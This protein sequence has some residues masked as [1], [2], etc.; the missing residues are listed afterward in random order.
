MGFFGGGGAAPANMGGATSSVAG[1]AGLVPAPAAGSEY[2]Y[3]RGDATFKNPLIQQSFINTT[4][5]GYNS[6]PL[7]LNTGGSIVPTDNILYLIPH[8]VIP[9]TYTTIAL[10][11]SGGTAGASMKTRMGV[12]ECDFDKLCPTTLILETADTS[13]ANSTSD[14]LVT[15]SQALNKGIYFLACVFTGSSGWLST[16]TVRGANSHGVPFWGTF[17]GTLEYRH[18]GGLAV[19]H[20]YGALPSSITA[21]NISF[22]LSNLPT[23]FLRK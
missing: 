12:Y 13:M 8:I 23:A 19:N 7:G 9:T 2:A 14:V 11:R 17:S 15:I 5:E 1:T 16:A 3:L 6:A 20:T 10:R 21:S 18:I 22:N 4:Q